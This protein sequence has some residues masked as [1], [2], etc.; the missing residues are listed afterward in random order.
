M[1]E[2]FPNLM[3]K[4]RCEKMN[5]NYIFCGNRFVIYVSQTIILCTLILY[6]DIFQL[7]FNT[8]VEI[9]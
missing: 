5:T 2:K 4:C 6:I 9:T 7:C 1:A 3:K 8:S